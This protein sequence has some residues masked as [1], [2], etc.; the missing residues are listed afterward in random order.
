MAPSAPP[1]LGYHAMRLA[2]CRH[3]LRQVLRRWGVAIVIVAVVAG[4]GISGGGTVV[5]ALAAWLVLPLFHA[6]ATSLL[7]GLATH[8]R[9]FR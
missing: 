4:G 2:W 7:Q 5:S 3:A 9:N 8:S 1:T 6:V